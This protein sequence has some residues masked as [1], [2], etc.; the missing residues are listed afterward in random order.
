MIIIKMSRD[1]VI[2][3]YSFRNEPSFARACRMVVS[4]TRYVLMYVYYIV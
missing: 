4:Y 2:M 1:K 3:S